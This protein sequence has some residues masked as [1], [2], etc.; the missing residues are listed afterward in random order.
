MTH[1]LG[2][3]GVQLY[4]IPELGILGERLCHRIEIDGIVHYLECIS[5]Q[6]YGAL[7][8]VLPTVH[9]TVYHIAV[10][11]LVCIHFLPTLQLH[12][13]IVVRILHLQGHG[14]TGRKVEDDYIAQLHIAETFETLIFHRRPFGVAAGV[15]ERKRIMHKGK[16]HWCHWHSRTV[17]QLIYPKEITGEQSLLER[18]RRN[19]IILSHE[20]EN[21]I[22]EDQC[23]NNGIDPAHNSPERGIFRFLPPCERYISGDIYIEQQQQEQ[24][25]PPCSEPDSPGKEQQSHDTEANP[26]CGTCRCNPVF[27]VLRKTLS[28]GCIIL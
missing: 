27:K 25:Y 8:I 5:G 1:L 14:I 19:L 26:A 3:R 12:K 15:Y 20:V 6:T 22:D 2:E 18:R 17:G 28:G 16:M 4:E 23:V 24:P 9:R 10:H 13:C 21:E 11:R 7:H